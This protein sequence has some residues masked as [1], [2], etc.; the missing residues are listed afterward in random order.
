MKQKSNLTSVELVSYESDYRQN[1]CTGNKTQVGKQMRA[2]ET[3]NEPV[4]E[5]TNNLGSP[6][7]LTQTGLYVQSQKMT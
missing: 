4:L 1:Q 2:K 6:P 7:G 3:I 5:K